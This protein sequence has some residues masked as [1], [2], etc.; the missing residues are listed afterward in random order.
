[1]W[2][3]GSRNVGFGTAIS[4]SSGTEIGAD[5]CRLRAHVRPSRP[6]ASPRTPRI[7]AIKSHR[8]SPI[9]WWSTLAELTAM[10]KCSFG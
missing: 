1:M 4:F 6:A 2:I 9:P 8:A 10:T 5:S 7:A 3:S